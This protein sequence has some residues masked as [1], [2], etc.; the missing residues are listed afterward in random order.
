MTKKLL[1]CSYAVLVSLLQRFPNCAEPLRGRCWS[2]GGGRFDFVRYIFVLN[3][4]CAQGKIYV[5]VDFAWS[6][7]FAYDLVPVQAPN[8][9]QHILSL[10]EVRKSCYSLAEH[11]VKSVYLNCIRLECKG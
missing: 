10:T 1:L 11:Y 2:S 6:K 7:Y 4:I 8:C 3:E 5:L 9:K